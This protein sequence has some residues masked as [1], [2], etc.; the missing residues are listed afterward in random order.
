MINMVKS[1]ILALKPNDEVRVYSRYRGTHV[2]NMCRGIVE[3][4]SINM[5]AMQIDATAILEIFEFSKDPTYNR[6][7]RLEIFDALIQ[8]TYLEVKKGANVNDRIFRIVTESPVIITTEADTY[9]Y[10]YILQT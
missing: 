2:N 6:R 1:S 9:T 5:G 3:S 4:L 8:P 7:S 10:D